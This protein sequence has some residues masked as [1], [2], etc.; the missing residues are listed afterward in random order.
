MFSKYKRDL[1]FSE[2]KRKAVQSQNIMQA[3]FLTQKN[4][5]T[6]KN[7]THLAILNLKLNK[8]N[9]GRG[10]YRVANDGPLGNENQAH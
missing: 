2:R 7:Y 3:S 6:K 4:K 5:K 8:E 9:G 10:M 1:K